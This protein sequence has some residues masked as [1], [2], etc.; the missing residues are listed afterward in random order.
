MSAD[1]LSTIR[2]LLG[3]FTNDLSTA[4]LQHDIKTFASFGESR[5]ILTKVDTTTGA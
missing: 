5:Q 2:I 3:E 1:L 4:G